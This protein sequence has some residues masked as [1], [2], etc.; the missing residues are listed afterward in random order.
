MEIALAR[1][2]ATP[3][4]SEKLVAW[5]GRDSPLGAT[6][7]GEGTNFSLFAENAD[8]V[9]LVL[10]DAEGLELESYELAEHTDLVWHGYVDKVGPGQHYGYRVHGRYAPEEGLRFN[11]HKL[12]LDPYA[13]AISGGFSWGPALLGYVVDGDDSVMSRMDSA[14]AMPRSVVIDP[15]FPWGEDHRPDIPWAD[16]VIY[17]THVKGFTMANED[18]PQDLRGTYAGLGHPAAIEHFKNLGVT[19]IELLPVHHFIDAGHLVEKG[20]VNYWGYDS[21]GYFAPDSRY[22]SSD[23]DGGQVREF[24]AMV[25]ALHGAG[26]EVVLDVV[27]NHTG[28]GDHMG[29]TISF[30]GLDNVAYYRLVEDDR[31]HYFDVTGTRHPLQPSH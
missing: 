30:R 20:L 15:S 5:P 3:K 8:A 9:D 27:Y 22:A 29:P 10:L 19:A 1:L 13:R 28:E 6:W 21:V 23:S 14:P 17:E 24:K 4:Q 7:D 26:L 12:L 25:R 31:R 2:R 11:P 18:V 16:T